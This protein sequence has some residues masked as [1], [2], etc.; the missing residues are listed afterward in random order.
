M[1]TSYTTPG[2]Y[3]EE[4]PATGPIQGVGTSTAG[5]IGQALS[6]PIETPTKITSWTQFKNTF[7]SYISAP[8]RYMAYAV[9]NF[10]RN[11][12]TVAYIVRVGTAKEAWL[13]LADRAATNSLRVTALQEGTTGNAITVQT[14]DA[15][16]VTAATALRALAP[17]SLGKNNA[18]TLTNA[19]DAALFRPGDTVTIDGTAERAVIDRITGGQIFLQSVL[20]ATYNNG[21]VRIADLIAT[22]A[23][24]RV[25]GGSGLEAGSVIVIAQGGTTENAV[26]DQVLAGF[27]TLSKGLANPKYTMGAADAAVGIQ[28]LEFTLVIRAPSL[29]DETFSNLAMDSRHSHYF[30]KVVDSVSVSV[31]LADPPS[32]AAP[33]NNR[34]KVIGATNLA[35]GA[36]DD[37][38][39]IS[40]ADYQDGIDSLKVIQDVNILCTPD[41]SDATVQQALITHCESMGDRV[42]VLDPIRGA[43]PYGVGSVSE[44]RA[45]L[46]S[47][48]GFGGLYY[49]WLSIPDPQSTTGDLLLVPP[50]GAVAGIYAQVDQARGVHKAPANVIIATASG[51]ERVLNEADMGQL[52]IAGINMIRTFPN[53]TR[54]IVWGARTT[55]NPDEAPWRYI[56]VR[57]LF[58]FV[59]SSIKLSLQ[60]AVFEPNDLGLWQK[61][62]RTISEFLTRVWRSGALFGATADQAFY[63]KC[64]A[65]LNPASVRALGQVFVEIGIAPV[66]PAEFVV[67]R[68]GIWDDGSQV[69]EQ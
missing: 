34:P 63:V 3:I 54:P 46:E 68:I 47:A 30:G 9:D 22:Q 20:T 57:R 62:I 15:Q 19:G 38:N 50:S 26:I 24:F 65:E 5:F 51:L 6:G 67:I 69:S 1:S 25:A 37:L 32:A 55:T 10:F 17:I 45:G 16:I 43:P 21:N 52:N 44:Q 27:V 2:V 53:A 8:R 58:C 28:S 42:A 29:P 33:P 18:I 48:R 12:G 7:G 61:L 23:T 49:P 60:W 31:A 39:A 56:N 36:N 41:R 35:N 13:D 11:G 66:R 14:S 4:L 64:D 40:P 59:E